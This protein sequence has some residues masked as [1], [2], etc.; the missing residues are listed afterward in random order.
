MAARRKNQLL[1]RRL[2]NAEVV[3]EV[4]YLVMRAQEVQAEMNKSVAAMVQRLTAATS[5]HDRNALNV[6]IGIIEEYISSIVQCGE[7]ADELVDGQ[8]EADQERALIKAARRRIQDSSDT[9][10]S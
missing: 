3:A 4:K 9:P 8:D 10:K 5:P 6:C 1:R 2:T 7:D